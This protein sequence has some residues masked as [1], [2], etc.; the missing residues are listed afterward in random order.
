MSEPVIVVGGGG[1]AGVVVD[2]LALLGR[3]ILGI[4][5]PA[6][7][8]GERVHG[9]RVLGDDAFLEGRDPA[10]TPLANGLGSTRSTALRARVFRELRAPGFRFETLVHPSAVVAASARLE[11]GVQVMAGAVVQPGALL[12][13]NA[14]INTRAS[15]DHDCRIGPDVHVAPGAVL[16][17][18]VTVGAGS[19]IGPG[20]VVVQGVRIGPDC[21]VGAGCLVTTDLEPRSRVRASLPDVVRTE[22]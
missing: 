21:H 8:R 15:V 13:A 11:E 9:V 10:S 16:S 2:V 1:H 17:G 18:G 4:I 14:L 5:D 22:S 19:H 3:E 12:E 6:L 7:G 20:A